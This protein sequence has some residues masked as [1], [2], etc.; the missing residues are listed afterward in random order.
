MLLPRNQRF[1]LSAILV[2]LKKAKLHHCFWKVWLKEK[3]KRR[4]LTV[5]NTFLRRREEFFVMKGSYE[6]LDAGGSYEASE[7][8]GSYSNREELF[9]HSKKNACFSYEVF[10]KKKTC[11]GK[12]TAWGI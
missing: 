7:A 3:K 8:G 2:S 10:F 11:C 5:E 1:S 6:A 12:K 4:L 9:F